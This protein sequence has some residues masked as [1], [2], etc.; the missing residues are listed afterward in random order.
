MATSAD[1][2][3]DLP[4]F[5]QEHIDALKPQVVPEPLV[6]LHLGPAEVRPLN[7]Q[8]IKQ[9]G[10]RPPSLLSRSLDVIIVLLAVYAV[11]L[12]IRVWWWILVN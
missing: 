11:W 2:D 3:I 5:T 9:H 4:E 10:P 7:N 12:I 8:W 6:D 1:D